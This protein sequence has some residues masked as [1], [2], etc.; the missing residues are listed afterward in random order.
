MSLPFLT[1]APARTSATTHA[2]IGAVTF[3]SA[4]AGRSAAQWGPWPNYR[5]DRG[6]PT[7][8]QLV[9]YP[10]DETAVFRVGL[11]VEAARL[12]DARVA[13]PLSRSMRR[14][15]GDDQQH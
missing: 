14:E 2:P 8:V 7:S 15:D 9:G 3:R 11:A 1:T 6:E 13:E 12:G 5:G 4:A 10:Y